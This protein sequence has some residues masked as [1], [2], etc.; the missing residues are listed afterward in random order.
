[1][2]PLPGIQKSFDEAAIAIEAGG[3]PTYDPKL[4]ALIDNILEG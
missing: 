3:R 2:W 4:Y 1:M